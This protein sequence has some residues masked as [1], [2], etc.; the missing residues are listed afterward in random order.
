[1]SATVAEQFGSTLDIWTV[2]TLVKTVTVVTLVTVV[3]VVRV[4]RNKHVCKTLQQ[5]VSAIGIT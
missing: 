4:D 5:F 2:V 1:M 3:A